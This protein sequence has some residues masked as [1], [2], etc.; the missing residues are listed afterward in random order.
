MNRW[1]YQLGPFAW[2]TLDD[3]GDSIEF[4]GTHETWRRVAWGLWRRVG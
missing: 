2:S 3:M 1:W 4:S